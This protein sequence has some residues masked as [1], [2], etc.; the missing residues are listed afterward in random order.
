MCSPVEGP[1]RTETLH[2]FYKIVGIKVSRGYFLNICVIIFQHT[3][4]IFI[5]YYAF[6]IYIFIYIYIYPTHIVQKIYTD[7]IYIY[8]YLTYIVQNIHRLYIYIPYIYCTKYTQIIYI[9][10]HLTYIVQ[11]IHRLTT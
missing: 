11:N 5:R 9:Y 6:Y 2:F 3:G 1:R 4:R 10:I 7:Y 8:T